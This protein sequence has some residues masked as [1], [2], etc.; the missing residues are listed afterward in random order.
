[1]KKAVIPLFPQWNQS[2]T[3]AS[4]IAAPGTTTSREYP[5]F[6]NFASAILTLNVT[7]VP[8][9][10]SPTLTV[11]V[12]EKDPFGSALTQIATFTQVTATGS[13]RILLGYGSGRT[14]A[15]ALFGRT[16]VMQ[17]VAGGSGYTGNFTFTLDAVVM[18]EEAG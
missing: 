18:T 16:L 6:A 15:G 17:Y 2:P 5:E 9:G 14:D 13:Q 10:T 3:P 12:L 1:M 7:A 4:T 8:T 11:N